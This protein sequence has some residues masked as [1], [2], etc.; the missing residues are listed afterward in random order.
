[1]NWE[2][3]VRLEFHT[4]AG[5][6]AGKTLEFEVINPEIPAGAAK[7]LELLWRGKALREQHPGAVFWEF[8]WHCEHPAIYI[9]SLVWGLFSLFIKRQKEEFKPQ[10]QSKD[11]SLKQGDKASEREELWAGEQRQEIHAGKYWWAEETGG[12]RIPVTQLAF[13]PFFLSSTYSD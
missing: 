13:S 2:N 5:I 3:I 4:W 6:W 11:T 12:C 9:S 10:V 1:M 7:L 8:W